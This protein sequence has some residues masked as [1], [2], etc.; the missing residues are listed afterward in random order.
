MRVRGSYGQLL[1]LLCG[2]ILVINRARKGESD[3]RIV[4]ACLWDI[5]QAL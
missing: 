3:Y 5:D 1:C 4:I 2:L